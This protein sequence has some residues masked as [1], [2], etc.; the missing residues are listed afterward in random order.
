MPVDSVS[1]KKTINKAQ[2]KNDFVEFKNSRYFKKDVNKEEIMKK[3]FEVI[4][5]ANLI[6]KLS[7]DNQ[8][9]NS[10]EMSLNKNNVLLDK[11]KLLIVK[12]NSLIL[13]IPI[14]IARIEVKLR[15][16]FFINEQPT[17]SSLCT[18]IEFFLQTYTAKGK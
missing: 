8:T 5:N 14:K 17:V 12:M 16:T 7:G 3:L 18:F 15:N 4:I 13:M 6:M 2:L 9:F 10:I 11:S 1:K